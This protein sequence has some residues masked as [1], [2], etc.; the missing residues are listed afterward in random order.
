MDNFMHQMLPVIPHHITVSMP[1]D[2]LIK[3]SH[4]VWR[5]M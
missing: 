2:I 5:A 3:L 1:S 4:C